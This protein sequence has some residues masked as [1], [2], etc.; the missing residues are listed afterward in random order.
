MS[1]NAKPGIGAILNRWDLSAST[2]VWQE[3][4]EVT[5]LS[6]SG[7]SRNVIEV[8]KLNNADDYV[9]KVQGILNA[10]SISATILFTQAQF[11]LMKADL[12]TRGSLQYQIV[13]PD[14]EGLE[15]SGFISE[16]PLDMGSDDVMQGEVSFEI[17]G[18]IDFL[19]T[20]TP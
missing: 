6:W 5:A 4:V 2:A 8:F 14:G 3:V 11:I 15:F 16:L 12:E 20:A 1:T 13:M 18:K 9:N 17:D 10:G 19:S 7:A